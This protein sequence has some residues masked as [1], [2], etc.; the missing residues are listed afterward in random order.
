M[1]EVASF[2]WVSESEQ[3]D[4]ALLSRSDCLRGGCGGAPPSLATVGERQH[5]GKDNGRRS[6]RLY[7]SFELVLGIKLEL[8]DSTAE[9]QRGAFGARASTPRA[10]TPG[11]TIS[12]WRP[13]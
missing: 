12:Y 6:S 2:N 4:M 10:E 11:E 13:S 5:C 9:V 8:N 7:I 3:T 1:S